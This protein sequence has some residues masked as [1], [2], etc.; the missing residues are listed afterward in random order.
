[1]KRK[2]IIIGIIVLVLAVSYIIGM[3]Y[4]PTSITYKITGDFSSS[5]VQ[6]NY[7]ATIVF[8]DNN[9]VTAR[10]KYS[11]LEGDGCK[12]NCKYEYECSNGVKDGWEGYA[13]GYSAVCNIENYVPLSR[14]EIE[15]KIKSGEYKNI[16]SCAKGDL[17]YEFPPENDPWVGWY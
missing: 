2:H 7:L 8:N 5:G 1:M 4:K 3:N 9:L 10:E 14:K 16:S 17:C 11:V 13:N 6:R 12:E 15:K